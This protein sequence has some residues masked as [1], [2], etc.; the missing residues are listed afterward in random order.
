MYKGGRVVLVPAIDLHSGYHGMLLE[1]DHVSY[2]VSDPDHV[3]LADGTIESPYANEHLGEFINWHGGCQSIIVHSARLPVIG[4]RHWVI[5]TDDLLL[6][7]LCGRTY[8]D[9]EFGER[10]SRWDEESFIGTTTR[11]AE[12]ML[13]AYA[14]PSCAGVIF[15]GDPDRSFR[16][17]RFWFQRMGLVEL[18]ERYLEKVTVVQPAGRPVHDQLLREKWRVGT[19]ARVLFCGRDFE[20]KNG[21]LALQVMDEMARQFRDVQFTYIGQ[22]PAD[23]LDGFA[24]L[25]ARLQH[26][27]RL[28]RKGVLREMERS[29]IFFHPSKFETVGMSLVEAASCGMAVIT[30]SGPTL[31]MSE[32]LFSAGGA[33]LFD[34]S[35][36]PLSAEQVFFGRAL[37]ALLENPASAREMG[38]FNHQ[39]ASSGQASFAAQVEKISKVYEKAMQYEGDPLG[40]EVAQEAPG[41]GVIIVSSRE[42]C[43]EKSRYIDAMQIRSLRVEL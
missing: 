17:A 11:R 28:D 24:H 2:A 1:I 37:Q 32:A 41:T 34:R 31:E 38:L 35:E 4:T 43:E 3:F 29:H 8:L 18:G 42:L 33:I 13:S 20:S 27:P 25:A 21:L 30:A 23:V 12:V 15:R 9:R 22:L 39:R 7:P 40:L 5:D 14:H 10:L 36:S 16:R 6:A 19:A 26:F